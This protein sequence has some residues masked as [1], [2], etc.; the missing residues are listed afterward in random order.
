[1]VSLGHDELKPGHVTV[2][3]T[4][5]GA[6]YMPAALNSMNVSHRKASIFHGLVTL[7]SDPTSLK[8]EA[9]I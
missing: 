1:M 5:T 4:D 9:W 6:P 8:M 3:V 7:C 2:F